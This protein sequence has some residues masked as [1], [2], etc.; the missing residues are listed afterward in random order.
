M[1]IQTRFVGGGKYLELTS[2]Q[3][4]GE[5]IASEKEAKKLIEHLKDVIQDLEEIIDRRAKAKGER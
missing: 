3:V 5:L 4:N 1:K 2:D